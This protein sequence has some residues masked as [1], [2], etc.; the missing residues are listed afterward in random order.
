[1]AH[2][3]SCFAVAAFIDL[4]GGVDAQGA[5]VE[6]ARVHVGAYGHD[7]FQL[8]FNDRSHGRELIAE[9]RVFEDGYR[10]GN[11]GQEGQGTE[12]QGTEGQGTGTICKKLGRNF[13]VLRLIRGRDR[14]QAQYVKSWEEIFPFCD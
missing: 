3:R 10:A 8:P 14:G 13:S 2:A 11:K 4:D 5:A 9:T 7:L 12:G 6:C 1:M